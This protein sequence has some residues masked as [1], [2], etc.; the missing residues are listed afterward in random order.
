MIFH[1][2]CSN[3]VSVTWFLAGVSLQKLVQFFST[4]LLHNYFVLS[5]SWQSN[6][7]LHLETIKWNNCTPILLF[8]VSTSNR[9]HKTCPGKME[10]R[11]L[12]VP[13]F[14]VAFFW[15][16]FLLTVQPLNYQSCQRGTT[17]FASRW[18]FLL[19]VQWWAEH[20]RPSVTVKFV[21][22]YV[23]VGSSEDCTKHYWTAYHYV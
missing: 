1:F 8:Q 18:P 15:E 12:S 6:L 4:I 17:T 3:D 5:V 14:D 16:S 9:Q 20:C 11:D 2:T 23:H 7:M 19:S 10:T 13:N 22:G 21:I